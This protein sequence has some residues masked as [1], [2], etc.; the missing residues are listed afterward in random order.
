MQQQKRTK[1]YF[2]INNM[3][4]DDNDWVGISAK[5]FV[6]IS[7]FNTI[8]FMML[9]DGYFS[10]CVKKDDKP[11]HFEMYMIN[12]T[13]SYSKSIANFVD[14]RRRLGH[15]GEEIEPLQMI[16]DPRVSYQK[17][18]LVCR[19]KYSVPKE[20][21]N[22]CRVDTSISISSVIYDNDPLKEVM[23]SLRKSL[24]GSPT[25]VLTHPTLTLEKYAIMTLVA[26][27]KMELFKSLFGKNIIL[28]ILEHVDGI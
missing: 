8:T 24:Y 12:A 23:F 5:P 17:Y 3:N 9:Q 10:F 18:A 25:Y 11:Q 4:P 20:E 21:F 1:S 13:E 28:T 2:I 6:H 16:T 27:E 26:P 19:F 15:R 7:S 22:N 14:F